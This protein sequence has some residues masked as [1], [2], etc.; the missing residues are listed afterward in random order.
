MPD[1]MKMQYEQK[2]ITAD[3]AAQLVKSGDRV[4]YGEFTMFPETLD[5]ALA[6]RL[7]ELENVSI[8]GV[9]YT[10]PPKPILADPERKHFILHDLHFGVVSRY[11]HDKNMC[12]Y[13]PNTYHQGPRIIHKYTDIDVFFISTGPMDPRGY[14][15][16]G[17]VNSVTGSVVDKSK[18]I[19]VEV[20][21]KVPTCL[22][23]NSESLH[24]SQIDY[25]VE[26]YNSPLPEIPHIEASETDRKI[27]GIVLN[28]IVDGSCLQLGIGGLPNAI[29]ELLAESDIKDLGVHSEMLMD[30]FVEL[31]EK[32][33]ITGS[34]K[35]IDKYK[36]VYA[37][38]LGSKKL[39][40]FLDHNPVCASYPVSYT[41]DPRIIALNDNLIAINN[42]MEVDLFTQVASESIGS[43]HISGTGGQ[44]DFIFGAFAS[45]GGKGLI[46]LNSTYTD[47]K[48]N[49]HSRIK[50]TLAPA[51]IVTVPRSIV[52]YIVTEYGIAQFKGKSTWERAEAIINLAHPQFRDELIQEADK[53][54][55]WV[56]SNRI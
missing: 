46:C 22:G 24:I 4:A 42:A 7:D 31:Y 43:R 35:A 51:T 25:V 16:L 39:Y 45:H 29:G 20:N 48:G 37:F 38:A 26:G 47:S 5:E 34:K 54:K 49:L 32:G 2:L 6:K 36:M 33:K 41:N 17:P 27:A 55:I 13:I 1:I 21:N 19:V 28:E 9:C 3:E 40:D 50:P 53:M 12:N 8:M 56:R 15:N 30:A 23:G 18:I 10:R 52:H 14:F 44:L 11:L